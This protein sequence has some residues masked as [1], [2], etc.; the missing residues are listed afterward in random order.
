MTVDY[1]NMH[2]EDEDAVF[3]LRMRMWN[4][5]SIEHVRQGARLD[6]RYLDHSFVAVDEAGTLLSSVRFW[7]RQIRN[8]SSVPEQVGCVASVATIESARRQGHARKLMQLAIEAMR[9]EGCAWSL[10]SSS[11]MGVPLYTSLGYRALPLRYTNGLLSDARPQPTGDYQ[12]DRIDAPFDFD[13][14]NW[15]AVRELY[16]RYNARRPLSLVRD[17]DYWRGYVARGV[18]RRCL[19]YTMALFLAR[20]PAGVP[21]AYLLADCSREPKELEG[22]EQQGPVD[23]VI[24]LT[25][26]GMHPD[27]TD[28]LPTLISAMLGSAASGTVGCSFRVPHEGGVYEAFRALF[29]DDPRLLDCGMMTLPLAEGITDEYIASIFSAPGALFWIIDDF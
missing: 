17:D 8:A 12:I 28:A 22:F 10:L 1:R 27:H 2:L 21:V 13:D 4:A 14:A 5:P 7:L 3:A 15:Q 11:D 23:Q 9:E 6:P 19:T 16:A 24:T 29:R 26:L 25:E 20:T 18:S